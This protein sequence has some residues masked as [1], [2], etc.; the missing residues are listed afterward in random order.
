MEE[1]I[2]C[3]LNIRTV[4]RQPYPKVI[5]QY[6]QGDISAHVITNVQPYR[7][8]THSL[9]LIAETYLQPRSTTPDAKLHEPNFKYRAG[10]TSFWNMTI[11]SHWSLITHVI[12]LHAIPTPSMDLLIRNAR[13][14]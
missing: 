3:L 12:R 4:T 13:A 8:V 10:P 11:N 9:G 7:P 14:S 6:L 5:I 1:L 2:D